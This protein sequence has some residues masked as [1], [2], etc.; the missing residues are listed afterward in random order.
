M[1]VATSDQ[2]ATDLISQADK[3]MRCLG[4][5][6]KDIEALTLETGLGGVDIAK[7][8]H[9]LKHTLTPSFVETTDIHDKVNGNRIVRHFLTSEG[10]RNM[11]PPLVP[12][13]NS[14]EVDPR[15][16]KEES[17]SKPFS[18]LKHIR[19][20][21]GKVRVTNDGKI[22]LK[23]AKGSVL[24]VIRNEPGINMHRL[25]E[26]LDIPHQT[27]WAAC[28]ELV[29]RNLVILTK[30]GN[31]NTYR[32]IDAES[33]KLQKQPI[34]PISIN[35]LFVGKEE[36]AIEAD[37]VAISQEHPKKDNSLEN[38]IHDLLTRYSA[39]DIL[40]TVVSE[41]DAKLR[42]MDEFETRMQSLLKK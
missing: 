21:S 26:V 15:V 12:T 14:P 22:L 34:A 39:S 8:L 9:Y 4:T 20:M 18:S 2:E 33:P 3:I 36:I 37:L 38:E 41:L 17:V 6:G 30:V 23:G 13:W 29:M 27:I 35:D 31:Q 1:G 16:K 7:A 24:E 25:V 10:K 19:G 11:P 40:L 42:L 28:N 32:E 5:G